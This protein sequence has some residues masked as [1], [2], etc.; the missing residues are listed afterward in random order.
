MK[1]IGRRW[2]AS[3]EHPIFFWSRYYSHYEI[4]ID[5]H[6]VRFILQVRLPDRCRDLGWH[7]RPPD[8]G[9]Y[10]TFTCPRC[11]CTVINKKFKE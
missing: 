11:G 10:W 2:E 7:V 6:L 5:L 8:L 9:N 3:S 1:L 4:G